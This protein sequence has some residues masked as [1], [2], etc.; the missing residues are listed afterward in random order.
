MSYF[1]FLFEDILREYFISFF[2]AEGLLVPHFYET[3]VFCGL[4]SKIHCMDFGE[5]SPAVCIGDLVLKTV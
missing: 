3:V 4:E 1:Q 2:C 5:N